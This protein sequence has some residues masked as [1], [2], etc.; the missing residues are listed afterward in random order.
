MNYILIYNILEDIEFH[1]FIDFFEIAFGLIF[2]IIP[3]YHSMKDRYSKK[4]FIKIYLYLILFFMVV[5]LLI[6]IDTNRTITNKNFLKIE[7]EIYNYKK[8][9]NN[10]ESF[11]V[12]GH[13]FQSA[14][15]YGFKYKYKYNKVILK[16]GYKV[17]IH[18]D[19]EGILQFWIEYKAINK[20]PRY[21]DH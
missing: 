8:T 20:L 4:K 14:N 21:T 5:K 3:A 12:D 18:Y 16:N 11:Y 17:K 10:Y 13:K 19:S 7:G 1:F 2:I 9:S 15:R 6:S